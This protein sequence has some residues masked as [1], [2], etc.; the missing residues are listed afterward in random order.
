VKLAT[1]SLSLLGVALLGGAGFAE[2]EG[3]SDQIAVGGFAIEPMGHL[4]SPDGA[5]TV[6]P[7]ALLGGGYNSNVYATEHHRH[8]AGFISGI[9][10]VDVD[11]AITERDRLLGDA[12][13][14]G[15]AY[16][17]NASRNLQGGAGTARYLHAAEDWDGHA[18][19][20][21]AR[22]N[23]P[24]ISTG[25]Q[26]KHDDIGAEVGGDYR[27][28]EENAA[29]ALTY[30]SRNY[31]EDSLTFSKDDR[32]Y[33]DTGANGRFGHELGDE[34]EVYIKA[35]WDYRNYVKNT[36]PSGTRG[37]NDSV[38]VLA[39]L[40]WK[41]KLWTRSAVLAELGA[42]YRTYR[43]DFARNAAYNDQNVLAPAANAAFLWNFEPGSY[44]AARLYSTI[45][46]SVSANAAWLY[47]AV[48]DGRYRLLEKA[49]LFGAVGAYELR[50]SG[51]SQLTSSP[52]VRDTAEITLGAEY[53]L[54]RGIAARLKE[55]YTDSNSKYFQDFTRNIITV[56]LGFVY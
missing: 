32:D 3:G 14:V 50:D 42:I 19:A 18:Q 29:L 40:G 1:C 37:F 54:S 34:S 51:H 33:R 55:I 41:S 12:E 46:D 24:F 16:Y 38:G 2:D 20:S 56:E 25:E 26:I 15:Q 27:W 39:M 28:S 17:H 4:T 23:D 48:V 43:Y 21:Y 53:A 49:A 44:V 13:Y 7:K 11:W 5:V 31:L 8:D 30:A 10:G 36:T 22:T 52:E 47:G 6:H 9:A 35:A 45:E